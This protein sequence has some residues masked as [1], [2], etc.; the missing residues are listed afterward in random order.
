MGERGAHHLVL[1]HAGGEHVA[2]RAALARRDRAPRRHGAAALQPGELRH[3]LA[4]PRV[5]DVEALRLRQQPAPRRRRRLAAARR[6][7][8]RVGARVDPPERA[9]ARRRQ[10]RRARRVAAAAR[11]GPPARRR[12]RR[13]PWQPVAAL[14]RRHEARHGVV[15]V[16]LAEHLD[17]LVV[18]DAAVAVRVGELEDL[19]QVVARD[20]EAEAGERARNLLAADLAVAVRVERGE[21]A[22]HPVVLGGNLLVDRV[23]VAVELG[24]G[25]EVGHRW[26]EVSVRS[27]VVANDGAPSERNNSVRET[28]ARHG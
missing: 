28:H 10:P 21:R 25:D 5:L 13:E 11:G 7:G 19:L 18:I 3:A 17:E 26:H 8:A 15:H 20:V 4:Q 23:L 27:R 9:H 12:R 24:V 16:K 1:V 22:A 14:E 6:L 2:A